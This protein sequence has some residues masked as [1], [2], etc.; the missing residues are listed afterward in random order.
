MEFTWSVETFEWM[1]GN[2]VEGQ[3]CGQSLELQGLKIDCE[4]NTIGQFK[5]D[6]VVFI[7]SHYT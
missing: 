5:Y 1:E 3:L 2:R 4:D 7:Q 6:I